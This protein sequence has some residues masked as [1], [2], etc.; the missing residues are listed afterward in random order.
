MQEHHDP[1]GRVGVRRGQARLVEGHV[2]PVD[3]RAAIEI[4]SFGRS[5]TSRSPISPFTAELTNR[6]R[7]PPSS[8]GPT[9]VSATLP[10]PYDAARR[11]SP[12]PPYTAEVMPRPG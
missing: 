11:P 6:P 9:P 5:R 12:I 3:A 1:T 4:A 7:G 2:A 10:S 8:G